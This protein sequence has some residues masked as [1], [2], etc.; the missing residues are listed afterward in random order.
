MSFDQSFQIIARAN[1]LKWVPGMLGGFVI[2]VGEQIRQQYRNLDEY[3][4]MPR[5]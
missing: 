4:L 1:L 5:R 2:P 3:A